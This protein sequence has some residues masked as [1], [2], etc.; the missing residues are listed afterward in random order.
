NVAAEVGAPEFVSRARVERPE[1]P[2]AS[3]GKEKIRSRCEHP[4]T[5]DIGHFEFPLPDAGLRIERA[6]RP[7]SLV[8]SAI[9]NLRAAQRRDGRAR[10]P[11]GVAAPFDI[12]GRKLVEDR[13]IVLPGVDVKEPCVWTV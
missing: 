2:L 12:L 10:R 9:D 4:R 6:D 5:G 8:F 3:P 13:G 7:I 1:I 11:G